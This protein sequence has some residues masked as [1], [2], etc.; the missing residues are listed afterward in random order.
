MKPVC[1]QVLVTEPPFPLPLRPAP[2]CPSRFRLLRQ[3]L[4]DERLLVGG[5][6]DTSFASEETAAGRDDALHPV[7]ARRARR[8]THGRDAVR[9]PPLLRLLGRDALDRLP[10]AGRVPETRAS[11]GSPAAPRATETCSGSP[12]GNWSPPRSPAT[13]VR[14]S[15]RSIPAVL[16]RR[17]RAPRPGTNRGAKVGIRNRRKRPGKQTSDGRDRAS[18]E[19]DAC[20][21]GELLIRRARLRT[22]HDRDPPRALALSAAARGHRSCDCP[23]RGGTRGRRATTSVVC[24]PSVQRLLGSGR[25]DAQ[26]KQTLA[27]GHGHRD[28]RG[29]LGRDVTTGRP[30]ASSREAGRSR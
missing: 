28:A 21:P 20:I 18:R 14:S 5:R 27:R 25:W 22:A 8:R 23:H 9:E 12:A 29:Q 26:V 17:E 19:I 6:R 16:R 24:P 7:A 11:S 2:L 13:S 3:Q 30:G 10:L 4:P 1:G 15:R